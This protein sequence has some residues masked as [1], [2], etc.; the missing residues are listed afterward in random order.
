MG[1]LTCHLA[2][3]LLTCY[4]LWRRCRRLVVASDGDALLILLTVCP[5][6][7]YLPE[8]ASAVVVGRIRCVAVASSCLA[9]PDTVA[10]CFPLDYSLAI[11][12]IETIASSRLAADDDRR[13][14]IEVPISS[15]AARLV[16]RS[17]AASLH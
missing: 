8:A 15:R 4:S 5:A 14:D 7:V 12:E 17:S 1:N 6:L 10:V 16:E 11:V 9:G 13:H 2:D 3:A